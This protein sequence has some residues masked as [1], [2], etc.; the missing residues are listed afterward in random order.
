[1]N[2]RR[3]FNRQLAVGH[4]RTRGDG[5]DAKKSS[6]P[7]GKKEY[8]FLTYF[9]R[10]S[11]CSGC[12]VKPSFIMGSKVRSDMDTFRLDTTLTE[13]GAV[14]LKDLL[15]QQGDS[16][17]VIIVPRKGASGVPNVYSLRGKSTPI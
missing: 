16:V 11:A 5:A 15:F 3:G 4:I 8:F 14:T 13:D 2:G 12:D 17:E 10:T 9:H 1:L 7:S 6:W